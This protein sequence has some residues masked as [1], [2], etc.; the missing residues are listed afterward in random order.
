MVGLAFSG[1]AGIMLPAWFALSF[2]ALAR[3]AV[4]A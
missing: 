2:A 3:S 1:P 4:L